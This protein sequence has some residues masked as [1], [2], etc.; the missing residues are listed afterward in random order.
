MI[1]LSTEGFRLCNSKTL[2]PVK[3]NAQGIFHFSSSLDTTFAHFFFHS[4]S[5]LLHQAEQAWLFCLCLALRGLPLRTQCEGII[6]VHHYVWK[7][8]H[9]SKSCITAPAKTSAWAVLH[10]LGRIA[11]Y[12]LNFPLQTMQHLDSHCV[13]VPQQLSAGYV[14]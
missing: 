8:L 6:S 1:A 3:L 7:R 12:L 9:G 5:S 10:L 11:A 2:L 4:S 14:F 13:A